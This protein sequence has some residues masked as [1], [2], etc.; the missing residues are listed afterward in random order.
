MAENSK[1]DAGAVLYME[2]GKAGLR[3]FEWGRA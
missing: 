1:W 3:F 2:A